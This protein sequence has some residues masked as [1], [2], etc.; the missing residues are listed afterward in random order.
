MRKY[1]SLLL[2]ALFICAQSVY[3]RSKEVND[4]INPLVSTKKS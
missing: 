4:Y 2:V 3:A 1:L